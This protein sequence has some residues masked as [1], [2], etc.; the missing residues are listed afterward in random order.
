[1]IVIERKSALVD[2]LEEMQELLRSVSSSRS[3]H[4]LS[5][6]RYTHCRTLLLGSELRP[7]MPGFLVQCVS[8]DKFQTFIYLYDPTPEARIGL[9]DAAFDK[10]AALLDSKRRYD[11]FEDPEF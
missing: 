3:P 2:A 8:L 1:L 11:V 7:A 10:V 6:V 9:V 4:R 5:A